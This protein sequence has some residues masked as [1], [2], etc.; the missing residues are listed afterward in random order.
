MAHLKLVDEREENKKVQMLD[1]IALQKKQREVQISKNEVKRRDEA[2]DNLE[3][4][5]HTIKRFQTEM[6]QERRI[7]QEKRR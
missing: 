4:E 7:Q 6:E 1:K 5:I 2:R 3:Q